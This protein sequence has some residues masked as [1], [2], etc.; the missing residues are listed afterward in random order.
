MK[1]I[2]EY[3]EKAGA[4]FLIKQHTIG[5]LRSEEDLD[6]AKYHAE[7][8]V[9]FIEDLLLNIDGTIEEKIQ[10]ISKIKEEIPKF[11][12]NNS[13]DDDNEHG[14][15]KEKNCENYATKD[16]NGH[17]HWVCDYHYNKLNDDFDEDY[18]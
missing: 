8:T 3:S 5:N 17:D 11:Y 13:T 4:L 16:Y 14:L 10:F 6:N 9:S 7:Q 18:R 12:G 2:E 1:K 15:C